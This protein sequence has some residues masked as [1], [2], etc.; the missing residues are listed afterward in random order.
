MLL[1]VDFANIAIGILNLFNSVA[2][3]F[4]NLLCAAFLM[5]ALGRIYGKKE[6]LEKDRHIY[7]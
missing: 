6:A 3:G 2:V 1:I 5:Y 4:I 7:E